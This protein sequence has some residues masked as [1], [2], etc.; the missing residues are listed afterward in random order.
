MIRFHDGPAAGTFLLLR[1]APLF[2][3]AVENMLSGEWNALDQPGDRP[4]PAEH[5]V[6]YRRHGPPGVAWICDGGRGGRW[7]RQAISAE[8]RLVDP[9]PP[10]DLLRDQAR[11]EQWCQATYQSELTQEPSP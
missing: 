7:G 1:R 9:Q 11:Y 4:S 10:D 8:Y 3:R 5:V 6:L 2:L